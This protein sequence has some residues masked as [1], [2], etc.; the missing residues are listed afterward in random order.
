MF[1]LCI[2]ILKKKIYNFCWNFRKIPFYMKN[3]YIRCTINVVDFFPWN[4]STTLSV[5][6]TILS[7]QLSMQHISKVM[8]V[9]PNKYDYLTINPPPY[10]TCQKLL[11]SEIFLREFIA[12]GTRVPF[13][14][15]PILLL[16]SNR[17][18]SF[19]LITSRKLMISN[20]SI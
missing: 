1:N 4:Y 17:T 12:I 6:H 18:T 11:T 8:L 2:L 5:L 20:N 14:L 15:F 10:L 7:I 16:W 3:I 19:Y 13:H 9:N